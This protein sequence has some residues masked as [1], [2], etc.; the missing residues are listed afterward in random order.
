M[1]KDYFDCI[2]GSR[3]ST[4]LRVAVMFIVS[5]IFISCGTTK[6]AAEVVAEKVSEATKS[7]ESSE[8]QDDCALL[9]IYRKSSMAGA[10]IS[11]DLYMGDEKIF[12]AKNKSKTT[13]KITKE[14]LITLKAK[15]EKTVEIALD[16]ELGKE[17]YVRC[18]M[19]MGVL[20][21]RPDMKIVDNDT[22]KAEFGKIPVETDK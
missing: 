7:Q 18:G 1:Q 15:T 5:T 8:L 10:A 4:L 16:I 19:K 2:K 22:G 12:R 3:R 17:Y 14:E 20:V 21:G 6:K 11:Y 13:I 9:H